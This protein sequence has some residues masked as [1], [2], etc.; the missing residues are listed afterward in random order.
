MDSTHSKEL[1]LIT[2]NFDSECVSCDGRLSHT[3]NINKEKFNKPD[4]CLEYRVVKM[5]DCKVIALSIDEIVLYWLPTT[6]VATLQL[7]T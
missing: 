4:G 3:G 1:W 6:S 2:D 5:D 7:E